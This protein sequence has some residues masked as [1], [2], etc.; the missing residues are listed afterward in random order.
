MKIKIIDDLKQNHREIKL[1]RV[2]IPV[3]VCPCDYGY[4]EGRPCTAGTV[5]NCEDCWNRTITK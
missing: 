3:N 2:G 4:E 1:N 5:D